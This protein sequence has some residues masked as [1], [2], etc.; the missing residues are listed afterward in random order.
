MQ[1]GD[2]PLDEKVEDPPGQVSSFCLFELQEK[3]FQNSLKLLRRKQVGF[4]N[5][6]LKQLLFFFKGL[7]FRFPPFVRDL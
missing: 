2:T 3:L 7:H 6:T 1:P 5:E 4:E